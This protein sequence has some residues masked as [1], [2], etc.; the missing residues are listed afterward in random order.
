MLYLHYKMFF[1]KNQYDFG[2]YIFENGQVFIMYHPIN[3]KIKIKGFHSF[4]NCTYD[5]GYFYNGEHHPFW[6]VVYCLGGV[7]GVS[8]DEKIYLLRK[9][10]IVI[11]PPN[12]HHKL[13]SEEN[14][15]I[16]VLVFSF[17]ATGEGLKELGGAYSCD[18]F[19]R[20]GWDE[21]A[22]NMHVCKEFKRT[23]GYLHYLEKDYYKYQTVANECENLLLLLKEHSFPL[24]HNKSKMA[25]DYERI[26]Q[27]MRKKP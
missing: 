23:A 17:E 9:G 11:Y 4:F 3:R 10:D 14:T 16:D 22:L 7:V 15:K 12:V 25:L 21:I 8:F 19:Q 2:Y 6:E 5:E 18:D 1:F 13:W 26:I 20:Q 24:G 27:T